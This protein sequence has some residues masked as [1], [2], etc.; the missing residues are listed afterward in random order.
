M[1]AALWNLLKKLILVAGSAGVAVWLGVNL[2]ALE[3][4][5][6]LW[7]TG[8]L[9]AQRTEPAQRHRHLIVLI[10]LAVLTL[11]FAG[12]SG[13]L[14]AKYPLALSWVTTRLDPLLQLLGLTLP[15]TPV[16]ALPALNA[17]FLVLCVAGKWAA[18][19]VAGVVRLDGTSF[20]DSL[21]SV[22]YRK[23]ESRWLLKPWWVLS[24]AYGAALALVGA[25]ALALQWWVLPELLAD[26]WFSVL[27]AAL[28][29]LGLEWYFWLS[30]DL[31]EQIDAEFGG[32]DQD[33][34]RTEAVFED[35]WRRYRHFWPAHWKAAGNRAP[36]SPN[37]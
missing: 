29:P 13:W 18:F 23:R 25:V 22:A 26:A 9:M 2:G 17:V 16:A 20:A 1:L 35:L 15:A 30:G 14:L 10:G 6:S 28:I 27:A 19:G 4:T 7:A 31:D 36:E 11:C 3:S 8:W 32:K 34:V 37:G 21:F 33:A 5:I 12:L 24:R